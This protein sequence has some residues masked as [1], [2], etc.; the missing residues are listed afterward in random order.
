MD[1]RCVS[2]ITV[3]AL[4]PKCGRSTRKRLRGSAR[5]RR[6]SSGIT[7][8]RRSRYCSMKPR[9][10]TRCFHAR[11]VPIVPALHELQRAV[12]HSLMERDGGGIA[13][14]VREDGVAAVDRLRIYRNT[15][16]CTLTN[17]LRLSYPAVHRLVGVDFF[18]AVAQAFIGAQ[19]LRSAY[20]DEYGS[21]F[22]DFLARFP[23]ATSV[24]YLFDVAQLEWAV[25]RALH[26]PDATPL[27]VVK[28]RSLE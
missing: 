8:Y 10:L 19:P 4:R 23:A 6:L 13:T 15:F 27:N 1:T 16:Y 14:Y 3:R 2:T 5:V 7:T 21:G 26:A 28:L 12:Y 18:E 11:R 9:T 20:L 25:T 24:P 17:A 22:P